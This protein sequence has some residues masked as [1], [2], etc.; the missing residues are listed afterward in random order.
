M[1]EVCPCSTRKPDMTEAWI[2]GSGIPALASAIYL[3][4]R[5]KLPPSHVHI[6]DPHKSFS[7]ALHQKGNSL[8]GYDQFAA[9]LP[10]PAGRELSQLLASIPSTH[11]QGSILDEIKTTSSRRL[12]ASHGSHPFFLIQRGNR[13]QNV[14]TDSLGLNMK[15]RIRLLHLLGRSDKHLGRNRIIDF[16]DEGFFESPFWAIWSAQFCF[17]PWH[18]AIELKHS[19]RQYVTEYKTLDILSCLDITGYYQHESLFLPIFW[20]LRRIQVDYQFDAKVLDIELCTENT[21][22]SARKMKVLRHDECSQQNLAASDI[23]IVTLGSL[24]SESLT[25]TRHRP[26]AWRDSGD[27]AEQLDES[28]SLWL[29]LANNNRGFGDPY[30]FC[31]RQAESTLE[32]FTIT[33]RDM[34][35]V[36]SLTSLVHPDNKAGTFISLQESQWKINLCLPMEPVF[37]NQPQDVLVF[38]GFATFPARIG[39]YVQK[40]MFQCSGHEILNEILGHLSLHDLSPGESTILIPR[41]M[42]RMTASLLTH[43]VGDRPN[44]TPKGTCNIGLIGQFVENSHRSSVD[45]SYGVHTAKT[46]VSMLMGLEYMLLG[47]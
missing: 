12:A 10:I 1:A 25:G 44:I 22:C 29:S 23:I 13:L 5:A 17:Q 40:T 47:G 37:P 20:Y 41:I 19:L 28:W 14:P 8:T 9:C 4:E 36:Q 11:V 6:L 27:I 15:Y 3:V 38:W 24:V 2:V 33:T 32:S 31:T 34:I 7:S 21:H 30:N 42:P 35:L 39:N 43:A 16:F 18:S 46:A 26:P 45:L